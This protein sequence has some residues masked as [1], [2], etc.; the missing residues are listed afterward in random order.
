MTRPPHPP[1][2]LRG[3]PA[4]LSL[5]ALR[6]RLTERGIPPTAQRLAVAEVV[7][8]TEEHPSAEAVLA[9]VRGR[10]PAISRATVYATLKLFVARGLLRELV[11]EEGRVVYDPKLERHHHFVD[12]ATG[13]IVD[14]PWE[15][16]LV[17]GVP[18]LAGFDVR[19]FQVV[20]RG[21]LRVPDR[22]N[23][24]PTQGD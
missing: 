1:R 8:A 22:S 20:M 16:L 18:A 14:V 3:S 15:S 6:A 11:L 9:A 12:E 21:A 17:R 19:E 13:A 10:V 7:L 4:A 2:P 24:N 23:P 5:P